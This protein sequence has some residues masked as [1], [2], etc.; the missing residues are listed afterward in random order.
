MKKGGDILLKSVERLNY[1]L[2][3]ILNLVYVNFLWILFT[4]FGLGIFGI[5]PPLMPW[6]V[7]AGDGFVVK[8]S[9]FSKPIGSITKRVSKNLSSSAGFI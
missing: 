6:L 8:A 3:I 7:F 2:T 1:V 5:G 4:I 9:L